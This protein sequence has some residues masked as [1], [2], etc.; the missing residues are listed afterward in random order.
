MKSNAA[1]FSL[2]TQR[3]VHP[4]RGGGEWRNRS[5]F[6]NLRITPLFTLHITNYI[7]FIVPGRLPICDHTKCNSVHIVYVWHTFLWV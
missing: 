6:D 4:M 3:F 7:T 5:E 1:L 2:S